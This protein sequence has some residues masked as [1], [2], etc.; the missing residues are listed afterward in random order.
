[1]AN[2]AIET[3]IIERLYGVDHD[4]SMALAHIGLNTMADFHAEGT[5]SPDAGQLITDQRAALNMVMDVVSGERALTSSYIRELHRGLTEHQDT[6][7]AIDP[8]G[9]RF[10]APL[11][12]G[13]W[14][15]QPNNPIQ[16][17]GRVHEYC[18]PEFVQDEID[19]LLAWHAEHEK[20]GVCAE[21][22]AAWLHHRFSQIHPF[23][24]GN[25]RVARALT[26]V[27]F[28]RGGYLVPV[29]R[30]GEH[31]SAYIDALEA[32]DDGDLR[33]LVDLF[34]EIQAADLEDALDLLRTPERSFAYPTR[35]ED[36]AL[37]YGDCLDWMREWPDESVDLV[38][39]DPPFNSNADYNI[40]FGTKDGVPAQVRGFTDTWKW[41]EAAARRVADIE[42]AIS[43][44]LHET[45]RA[46]KS[47]LGPSGMLSYLTYM[48]E[49]LVEMR[50][51]LKQAG[52]IYLHCDPTASHYLK[53]LMDAIFGARQFRNE[54]VWC[55]TGPGNV[56]RWFPRKHDVLL[57]YAR[58]D[59][60]LFNR[61]AV[62]IPYK[63]L[64]VQHAEE[65]PGSGIGGR[66]TPDTVSDYRKRGKVP[67]DYWL[68]GRDGMTPVGRRRSE[69]LGYPTQKPL[70]LL[71]RIIKASS[72][73]GD[74]VL[75]PFCGCGTAVVSAHNLGRRWIGVDIS[76]TAIDI[77]QERRFK[78]M[79]VEAE[80]YGIP[81]D[82]A[83]ARKLAADKPF[84]FESWAVTRIPGLARN[85][86][87][88]GD[89]GIDGRGRMLEKPA[90]LDS[91]LVLAQV[92]G[93]AGFVLDQFRAFMRV[94]DREEA[95]LGVYITLEPVTS[96]SAR[97]EAAALGD[98]AIGAGRYPRV[99]FWSIADHFE[100]RQP[101]LPTL[102]DPETGRPME[103]SLF[104]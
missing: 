4:V 1:M 58:S 40:I 83:S 46:F 16:P 102:A 6:R 39:L 9:R 101:P 81:K 42:N 36:N 65:E 95:A 61:D 59:S 56:V 38:Y 90:D 37:Y 24:D 63:Q 62:R 100:G 85:E 47:L 45:T 11:L 82:L 84:D 48:G 27:V 23:E 71:D 32:A 22:E 19:Q 14:K 30:D 98:V 43:H 72:N 15:R 89:G 96:P 64:N 31:R 20:K 94:L 69:R 49:R 34:A 29:V 70:A 92:K 91:R 51:L 67:E 13:D 103:P 35:M 7:D 87:Q 50:R 41:N 80:T 104:G 73:P 17:D 66:L 21:V 74:L 44:P 18:P 60:A 77:I 78:Q 3:G 28:L 25:G 52:S 79:G 53:A 54:I 2:W 26:A 75:D 93:G 33:P 8:Q 10:A 86:H 12:K 99:Q 97:A 57:F 5:L 55:Y 68:E 88:R 76:A